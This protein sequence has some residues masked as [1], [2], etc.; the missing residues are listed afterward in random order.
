MRKKNRG[1]ERIKQIRA[2]HGSFVWDWSLGKAELPPEAYR[3]LE[4]GDIQQVFNKSADFCETL[5]FYSNETGAASAAGAAAAEGNS[6][7]HAAPPDVIGASNG[8][9]TNSAEQAETPVPSPATPQQTGQLSAQSETDPPQLEMSAPD[10]TQPWN[11]KLRK[12][13]KSLSLSRPALAQRLKHRGVELTPDA[14]K[15]H[16][17][18]LS[19]PKLDTRKAYAAVFGCPIEDLFP[20]D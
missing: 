6:Q 13:R 1:F 19:M 11:C 10:A 5:A 7:E 17:Y 12:A 14:I 16:E 3:L 9:K 4:D 2:S 18:G 15:K 20:A 8:S